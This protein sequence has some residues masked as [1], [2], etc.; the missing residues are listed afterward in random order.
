M[1]QTNKL[2]KKMGTHSFGLASGERSLSAAIGCRRGAFR[3]RCRSMPDYR[4]QYGASAWALTK[5]SISAELRD[6]YEPSTE[7]PPR[8]LALVGQLRG[9]EYGALPKELPAPSLTLV[10]KLDAP[11]G[12]Q[13]SKQCGG[14]LREL[15]QMRRNGTNSQSDTEHWRNRAEEA[16]AMAVQMT[17]PHTKAIMLTIAQDYEKLAERAE[18]RSLSSDYSG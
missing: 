8:L 17:D 12:D 16:R 9:L 2:T 3:L 4:A 6:G 15:P 14:R 1:V 5:E 11:E 7:L 18:Q 10:E 13:L